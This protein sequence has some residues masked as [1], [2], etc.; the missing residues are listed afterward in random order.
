MNKK[1]EILLRRRVN[2]LSATFFALVLV[3]SACKKEETTI[4]ADFQDG[5]LNVVVQDTFSIETYS[6]EILE[7]DSDEASV[8]LLGAYNDPVFGGV[9]CGIVTQI[10]PNDLDPDFTNLGLYTMDS[11]VLALRYT[12]I[13]YYANLDDITV[14]VFEIAD[15]LTRIDQDY[16]TSEIPTLV[17]AS[18]DLVRDEGTEVSVDFVSNSVVGNDTLAPQLRVNLDTEMGDGLIAD[19]LAGQ[20][21]ANFQTET[22]KG[23][24]IRVADNPSVGLGT[25]LYFSMEDLLSKITIYYHREDGVAEEYDFNIDISTAR[26]NKIDYERTGTGVEA[27]LAD[28]TLGQEIFYMQGGAVRGVVELPYITDFYTNAAGE[29]D[30]KI[31]NK[32]ELI[33]PVQD[34]EPDAFNP[35]SKLFIARVVDEKLSTFIL[36][37]N[38]GSSLAGNTVNYDAANKEFRFIMTQE[39]QAMLN[40][41]FE[42]TGYRIYSPGFFAST[43]ERIIFN[44]P[45]SGLKDK[46]RLEIT[47][48]EY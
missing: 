34:Y 35:T 32:A 31:I 24:Y 16:Y 10:V 27:L 15:E 9:N 42:N 5:N 29:F 22:F 30:P 18:N 37:Y 46:P 28:K 6:E 7:M 21:G 2:K 8:A 39:I 14:E 17:D 44:G 47:Y 11:V 26:Y 38:L 4:G 41:D 19:A 13:N 1:K 20:M 36:D 40:G 48:T 12:S 45:N 25:I 43:V 23:I 3:L 33:L